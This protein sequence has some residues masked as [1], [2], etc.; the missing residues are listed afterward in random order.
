MFVAQ[1]YVII[2]I[3]YDNEFPKFI[4][5][6]CIIFYSQNK[7]QETMEIPRKYKENISRCFL[8]YFILKHKM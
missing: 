8:N 4:E 6:N 7:F 3:C 5:F 1:I 2:C